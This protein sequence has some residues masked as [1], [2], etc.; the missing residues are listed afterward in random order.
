MA[1]GLNLYVYVQDNPVRLTDSTGKQSISDIQ[2]V[3]GG[4]A[5][6]PYAQSG[7]IAAAA[8]AMTSPAVDNAVKAEAQAE[9]RRAQALDNLARHPPPVAPVGQPVT[10]TDKAEASPKNAVD[11]G[12][13]HERR[14]EMDLLDMFVNKGAHEPFYGPLTAMSYRLGDE[15]AIEQ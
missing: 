8:L 14:V 9:A 10:R 7:A 4:P 3:G 5:A 2:G 11:A 6:S 1:D 13:A 12:R 15:Q